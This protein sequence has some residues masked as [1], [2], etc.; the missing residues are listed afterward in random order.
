MGVVHNKI[1]LKFKFL[2][3]TSII[4][5]TLYYDTEWLDM[6]VVH[7]KIRLKFK[8][9]VKVTQPLLMGRLIKY[10]QPESELSR[11]EAYLY[12]LG[13]SLCSLYIAFFHQPVY[14]NMQRNGLW[15]RA[16]TCALIYRK[17]RL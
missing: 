6:G 15:I 16:A 8:E 1:R 10:F 7:N 12:A 4:E 2:L 17:V 9:A 11:T 13:V 5:T 3:I 14:L